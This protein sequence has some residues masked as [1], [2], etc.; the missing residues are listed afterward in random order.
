MAVPFYAGIALGQIGRRR[1]C[2]HGLCCPFNLHIC[3]YQTGNVCLLTLKDVGVSK[4]TQ[5]SVDWRAFLREH[6]VT[7]ILDFVSND[8]ISKLVKSFFSYLC[9]FFLKSSR[10]PYF[11]QL[12]QKMTSNCLLIY[13]FLAV[14]T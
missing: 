7:K 13:E 5:C 11:L 1:E 14:P 4:I 12:S 10:P 6:M 2:R 9:R 8:P 3:C